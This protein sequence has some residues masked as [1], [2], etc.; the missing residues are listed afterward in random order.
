MQCRVENLRQLRLRNAFR[1]FDSVPCCPQAFHDESLPQDG[2]KL[3]HFCSMCGPKF[4]SMRITDDIR[5]YAAAKGYGTP[6]EAMQVSHLTDARVS[7]AKRAALPSN[8]LSSC[9]ILENA[10]CLKLG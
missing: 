5:K 3:A 4:C 1:V 8:V 9:N 2:A 7:F 6:E 10:T